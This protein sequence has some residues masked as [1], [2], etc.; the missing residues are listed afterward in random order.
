M[1][2]A[3]GGVQ[4]Y[5][6]KKYLMHNIHCYA[7]QVNLM[8]ENAASTTCLSSNGTCCTNY[9]KN[10]YICKWINVR[11]AGFWFET[12]KRLIT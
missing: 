7:H 2:G 4:S 8:I 6:K 9:N 5:N 3:T 11:M 10:R 1:S 12:K